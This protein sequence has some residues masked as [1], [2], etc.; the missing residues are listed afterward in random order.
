MKLLFDLFP[1]ILF[2][3]VYKLYGALPLELIEW[4]NLLPFMVLRPGE[5]QDA[6]L[7]ATLVAIVASFL[8]VSLHWVK[9]R[10]FEKMHLVSL[11][12]ITVFGGATLLL[13]DPVFIKWK[14]TI[15][16]WLFAAAFL[17]SQF[18]GNK[19]LVERTMGHAITV[20]REIWG[21]LNLAWV[22]FFVGSGL[23]NLYVAYSFSE[24]IWVS[25]KLFG[26]LGLTV[27]FVFAQALYLARY[28]E[29]EEESQG[30]A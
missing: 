10:R 15:L 20:P 19:T 23:A 17:A 21:Y 4:I 8:Q 16:N 29:V 3:A 14:P 11:A 9:Q 5:T 25:F 6:I 28:M 18:I 26:L 12:L 13:R 24:E 1:I 27:A 22:L 30:D 2:F 7:L